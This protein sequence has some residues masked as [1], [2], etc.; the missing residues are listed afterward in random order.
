MFQS[1]PP[2]RGA[3]ISASGAR[4][5][6]RRFNPRPPCGERH[7][8]FKQFLTFVL[9][10]STPP[11]RGATDISRAFPPELPVSIHAP[12][13]GSDPSQF[14]DIDVS[15][16]APRAGSDTPRYAVFL[17]MFQSTP[18]VRGATLYSVAAK[19]PSSFNPRPPCGE[20]RG[21]CH[22]DT[23]DTV[24]IHAPRAGSDLNRC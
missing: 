11:V 6:P 19:P 1:T 21:N 18:P 2:V 13:A 22:F 7:Q 16:H 8:I 14:G 12:R 15:I 20:R 9:F 10:Q 24:S 23:V 4:R 3:T 5:S 17:V